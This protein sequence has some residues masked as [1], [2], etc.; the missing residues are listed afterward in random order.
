MVLINNTAF[1]FTNEGITTKH[2][3]K[4]MIVC[5]PSSTSS[6]GDDWQRDMVSIKDAAFHFTNDQFAKG[7][8][9]HHYRTPQETSDWL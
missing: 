8:S 5:E 7:G 9:G 2:F 1:D 4:R 3:K 6:T